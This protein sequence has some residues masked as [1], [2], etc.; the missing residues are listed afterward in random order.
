MCASTAVAT[1]VAALPAVCVEAPG[2]PPSTLPWGAAVAAWERCG[3]GE[4]RRG[5][6]R[7]GPA[8]TRSPGRGRAS[9]LAVVFTDVSSYPELKSRKLHRCKST[10]R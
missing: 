9:Q 8:H 4:L 7:R 10:W 6:H 3:L 1:T 2:Q 5:L